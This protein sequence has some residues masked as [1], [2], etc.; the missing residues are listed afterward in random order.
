MNNH[1]T[2]SGDLIVHLT[3]P[4]IL[5]R[6]LKGIEHLSENS[7]AV[8]AKLDEVDASLTGVAADVAALK[9]AIAGRTDMSAD[10]EA[11]LFA[12]IDGIAAR[13]A[14]LDAETP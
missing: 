2:V 13:V 7:V 8:N 4:A 9:D 10:E 5:R 14:G 1:I 6:I 12:R 11:A 3:D